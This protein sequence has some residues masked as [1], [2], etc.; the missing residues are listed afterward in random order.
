MAASLNP[1]PGGPAHT[2]VNI[3][4]VDDDVRNIFALSSVLERHGM[5]RGLRGGAVQPPSGRV[6][7]A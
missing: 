7:A 3:L 5:A 2:P 1:M 6:L 4:L